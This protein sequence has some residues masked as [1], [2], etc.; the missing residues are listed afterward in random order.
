[1]IRRIFILM[2]LTCALSLSA[3]ENITKM[4]VVNVEKVFYEYYKTKIV[5]SQIE[6]QQT[7]Y[8]NALAQLNKQLEALEK[9][10]RELRD[11]AENVTL[12]ESQRQE[13][14]RDAAKK[15]AEV[16]AKRTD[17]S[18][19]MADKGQKLMEMAENKRTEIHAEILGE[20]RRRAH[21]DGIDL[22]LDISG[23]TTTG[24]PAVIFHSPDIDITAKI[25][26]ELNRGNKQAAENKQ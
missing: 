2:A 13:K 19:Y 6:E 14:A 23:K 10:Y 18:E 22:V 1:M 5:E 3:A 17:V 26:E 7:I 15:L 12:K 20:V 24:F 9:E 21:I 8:A 4:A 16:N 11:A 25:I